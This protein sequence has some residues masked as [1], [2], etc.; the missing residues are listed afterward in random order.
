MCNKCC[1]KKTCESVAVSNMY[2]FSAHAQKTITQLENE[3]R[4]L[5]LVKDKLIEENVRLKEQRE[6]Y[7]N[8]V[9]YL[10]DD[11]FNARMEIS[12]KDREIT[13]LKNEPKI[14]Q[15]PEPRIH[16]PFDD[17]K[18]SIGEWV[19]IIVFMIFAAIGVI[20][21]GIFVGGKFI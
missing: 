13:K 10:S 21:A 14:I 3:N 2:N 7:A 5:K 1:C 17:V 9:R 20:S 15:V 8:R 16:N 12:R 18:I 11:V 19:M 4:E 6:R